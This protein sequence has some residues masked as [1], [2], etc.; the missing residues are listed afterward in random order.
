LMLFAEYFHI[1]IIRLEIKISAQL[2]FQYI[3][4]CRIVGF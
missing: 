4:L 3:T 2:S 1:F